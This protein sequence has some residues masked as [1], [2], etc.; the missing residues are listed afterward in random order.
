MH[1]YIHVV[2]EPCQVYGYEILRGDL[3]ISPGCIIIAERISMRDL[4][5]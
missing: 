3:T 5:S 2:N 1:V 4:F